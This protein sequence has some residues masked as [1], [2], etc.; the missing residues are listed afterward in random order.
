VNRTHFKIYFS[1]YLFIVIM[2]YSGFADNGT[3]KGSLIDDKKEAA[4][5]A[6]ILLFKSNDSSLYKGELSNEQGVFLFTNIMY[7]TYRLEIKMIGFE[8][9]VK[10]NILISSEHPDMDLGIIPLAPEA[11]SLGVVTTTADIPFM[12]KKL[13]KTVINVENSIVSTGTSVMEIIEKLPGVQVSQ[14]GEITVKGQQSVTVLLDGKPAVLS[15]GE[16]ANLLKSMNSS[17]IQKIE[18]MAKPSAKYDA[19]GSG[20]MIN[21]VSKK[22]RKEGLN[23]SLNASYGQG[24]YEKCN[25]GLN[26]NYKN[27]SYNLFLNYSF[28]HTIDFRQGYS[29]RKFLEKDPV[30]A[31]TVLDSYSKR[32]RNSHTPKLGA[33]FTLSK[34]SSI[35]FVGAG[36]S[37]ELDN[38]TNTLSTDYNT[39][40]KKTGNFDFSNNAASKW[41]NYS[42]NV[43]FQHQFDT[44]GTDLAINLDLSTYQNKT[45]ES[46]R[47]VE[48]DSLDNYVDQSIQHSDQKGKLMIYSIKADYTRTLKAAVNLEAGVKSSYVQ[49]DNNTKFFD[50]ISDQLLFNPSMSNHFVYSENINAAYLSANKE[51]KKLTVQAGLRL[52]QTVADGTQVLTDEKFH[53]NYFQLF[54][55]LMA[56]FKI[57]DKH[58]LNAQFSKRVER[59]DYN[60]MNPIRFFIN[61]KTYTQGNP[62]LMPAISYGAELTYSFMDQLFVT[63]GYGYIHKPIYGVM[64]QYPDNGPTVVTTANFSHLVTYSLDITYSKKIAKWWT[65]NTTVSPYYNL[66]SGSTINYT[67]TNYGTPTFQLGTGNSFALSKN[68]SMECNFN[69]AYL[70]KNS[71]TAFKE[72]SILS[73]GAKRFILNNR[74]SI[75]LNLSDAFWTEK[76]RGTTDIRSMTEVWMTKSDTRV[77]RI[78]F[79]YR[80][81]ANQGKIRNSSG[82][83]E[84]IERVKTD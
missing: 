3:I 48:H 65:T 34:K 59:P 66:T 11:H 30:V 16:L 32:I 80:F 73:I 81:G 47:S 42:G 43:L 67:L 45:S 58:V 12:E 55:T 23:G 62:F 69:Y 6:N 5:Y 20:G 79:S 44:A 29:T 36:L 40:L 54:P 7:G 46:Y 15:G 57:S 8:K 1:L 68:F 61:A 35:S 33:D 74:G 70:R 76:P 28:S 64:I 72:I 9:V 31:Q 17:S 37:S 26:L 22:S 18:I 51:F 75:T 10:Q 53:R 78:S 24:R 25:S 82:A 21:I 38:K 13:D 71:A 4:P 39:G 14:E 77:V 2:G 52:E 49:S 19:V 41:Y 56:D 63:A 83:A 60:D 27:G 50:N 84:E